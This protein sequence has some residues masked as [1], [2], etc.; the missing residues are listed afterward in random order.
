[1]RKRIKYFT[2]YGCLDKGGLRKNSP[3][4]D[5][6]TD[7]IVSVLNRIGYGVDIISLAPSAE[8]YFLNSSL[9]IEKTNRFRYF[10]SFGITNS[11]LRYINLCLMRIQFIVWCIFNL[12]KNEQII[13]YHSLGYDKMFIWL[14]KVKKLRIV[15]EIEEIYQDVAEQPHRH[16]R[17]EF[18]FIELCAKY[19]F[20]TQFLDKNINVYDKPSVVVHG[21]YSRAN[22]TEKKFSD[23]KV[24]VVYGG[25]LDP[26]K[27]GAYAAVEAATHLSGNYHIHICGFGD[28]V[29]IQTLIKDSQSEAKATITFEGEL[30]GDAYIHFIQKCHIGLSTQN[31]NAKFN[32]TSFPSKVLVYL[33]NGLKVVSARIPVV[34]NSALVDDIF[35][36]DEQISEKIAEAIILATESPDIKRDVLADLDERFMKELEILLDD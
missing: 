22:I 35:F 34:V 2:Y 31:P 18:R 12:R 3:A 30:I 28:S 6:K 5:T 4:A 25:T 9:K 23:G 32:D 36:Y 19:I 29:A 21:I 10:A 1:M 7:Y 20:P 27:G 24:H 16:R 13:V 8:T 33:S 17:N 26:N 14:Q 11:F 15:G